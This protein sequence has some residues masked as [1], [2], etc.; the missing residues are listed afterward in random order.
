MAG[1]ES[2][3]TIDGPAGSGK[4]TVARNLARRLGFR[5]LDTGAMY[6]AATLAALERGVC[7]DPFDARAALLALEEADLA[8]GEN[9]SVTLGGVPVEDRIRGR[10]V[11]RAVS[12][13]AAVPEVRR[14][15][16]DLQRRFARDAQ[17]GLV[18]EGRDL[19]TVVFPGAAYRFYLDASVEERARRRRDEMRQQGGEVPQLEAMI[20]LIRARDEKDAGRAAA[21]LRVGPGVRVIDTTAL[22]LDQVIER[23]LAE[24]GAGT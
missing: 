19:A 9:G 2:I 20:A 7:C 11:T 3:V 22:A 14:R 8:L 5:F 21:P 13:V 1:D 18:A 10:E 15:L 12:A 6:R 23:I 16:T 24:M 17:P 4:T